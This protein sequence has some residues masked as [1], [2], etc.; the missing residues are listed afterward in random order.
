MSIDLKAGAT[1]RA[2][3]IVASFIAVALAFSAPLPE[4][5]SEEARRAAVIGM[6]MAVWWMS[7][8]VP[9]QVTALFPIATFPIVGVSPLEATARSYAHPL[10]FLF[11]GG[12]LLAVAMQR[13]NLHRRLA[14]AVLAISGAR[15]RNQV[16]AMMVCTAFLSLWISNTATAMVMVP[17][18]L[19]LVAAAPGDTGLSEVEPSDLQIVG[20]GVNKP[21]PFS[22][23]LMLGVAFAATIGGMGSLIGTPANALL[24]GLVEQ[25]YGISIGFAQW[26]ALGLPIVMVLL[27]LTWMLLTRVV[28]KLPGSLPLAASAATLTTNEP[29]S[30]GQ[31]RVACVLAITSAAWVSR[32]LISDAFGLSGL[33]DAGIAMIAA[34]TLF[35]L[36]CCSS[37]GRPLLRWDEAKAIRWD[38]LILFGGGLALAEAI[39]T[40][41]L[42]AWISASAN[43]LRNLPVYLL[44][45]TMMVLIVYLGELA[46][47]TAMAAVFLPIAGATAIGLDIDPLTLLIPVALAASLGFMLPVATPPNAIVYGTGAVSARQMLRAGAALD[48]ISILIVFILA[49]II[50]PYVFDIS[51]IEVR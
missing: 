44:V 13:W 46:S 30:P 31:R 22:A 45:L 41:G 26:M 48:V 1:W 47:N 21:D 18:S 51:A 27:P 25:S 37:G 11:L 17:I 16:L 4:G 23:A 33:S 14:V 42:A 43:I 28:F 24:A 49:I 29:M 6:I 10:I 40:T 50:G 35:I 2:I 3:V 9:L 12:F 7:E 20:D 36:P 32:P 5:L 39:G 8:V 19:S 15:P 38:V 34:M